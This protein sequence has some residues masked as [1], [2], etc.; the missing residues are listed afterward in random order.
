MHF[1]EERELDR[2]GCRFAGVNRRV[3]I[4]GCESRA[5]ICE[6]QIAGSPGSPNCKTGFAGCKIEERTLHALQEISR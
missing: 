3:R 6:L 2:A 4:S 1:L 5:L